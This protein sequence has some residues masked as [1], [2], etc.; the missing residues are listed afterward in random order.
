MLNEQDRAA[1]KADPWPAVFIA[2]ALELCLAK[3]YAVPE[4]LRE[5]FRGLAL[6]AIED[7]VA[8]Q[9]R[10]AL[11][12]CLGRLGDPRILSLRDPEAY[13]EV[14]AG[15]YPCRPVPSPVTIASVRRNSAI[16]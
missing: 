4:E 16:A 10:H 3:D 11:G 13:V 8:L 6:N 15:T 1:A 14:P 7:E 9:A 12:L 2:E 5:G